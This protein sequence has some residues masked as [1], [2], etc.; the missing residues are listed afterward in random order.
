MNMTKVFFKEIAN[1]IADSSKGILIIGGDFIAVQDGKMDRTPAEKGPQS[2]KTQ[3][4][5]NFISELGL[6]DP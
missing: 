4:L 1:I 6:K 5:N 2:A 3:T